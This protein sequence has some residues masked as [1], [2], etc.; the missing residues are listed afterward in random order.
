M[1]KCNPSCRVTPKE[2]M[3][4]LSWSLEIDGQIIRGEEP[5]LFKSAGEAAR[6]WKRKPWLAS[7]EED[8]LPPG[9]TSEHPKNA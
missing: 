4:R 8:T 5:Q 9:D 2:G 6:A 7:I 3:F 1:S